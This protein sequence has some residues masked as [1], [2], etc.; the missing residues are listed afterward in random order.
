MTNYLDPRI[1][2]RRERG[3]KQKFLHRVQGGPA[4]FAQGGGQRSVAARLH[5]PAGRL[6]RDYF[7]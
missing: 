1:L 4:S 6:R 5:L 7:S 3:V 2:R